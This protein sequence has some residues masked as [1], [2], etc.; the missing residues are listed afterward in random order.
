MLTDAEIF[1]KMRTSVDKILERTKTDIER[2]VSQT[3][4]E[5]EKKYYKKMRELR[6]SRFDRYEPERK[7]EINYNINQYY[8]N[9]DYT[10]KRNE[11]IIDCIPAPN[12]NLKFLP[13]K[14]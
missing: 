10:D 4:A 8:T 13:F 5:L 11:R 7:T 1:S 2:V 12:N 3:E 14:K 9:F 6:K